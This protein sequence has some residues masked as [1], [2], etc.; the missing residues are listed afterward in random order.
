M[1]G[2]Y[3]ISKEPRYEWRVGDE[4]WEDRERCEVVG[5]VVDV[6][7][8]VLKRGPHSPYLNVLQL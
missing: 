3:T 2:S 4:F 8:D 1:A 7:I 5:G 6:T